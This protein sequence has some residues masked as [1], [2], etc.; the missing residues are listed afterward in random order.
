MFMISNIATISVFFLS[1]YYVDTIFYVVFISR[2]EKKK[3]TFSIVSYVFDDPL[4]I[5][6]TSM[7]IEYFNSFHLNSSESNRQ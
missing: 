5:H 7:S 6:H 1:I 4:N 2:F 3:K